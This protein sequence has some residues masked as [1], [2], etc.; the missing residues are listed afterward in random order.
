MNTN[1]KKYLEQLLVDAGQTDL[2]EAVKEQMLEDLNVRLEQRLVLT[3]VNE[4]S[5]EQQKES[6]LLAQ[7]KPTQGEVESFLRANI[8]DY[9]QVFQKVFADFRKLYLGE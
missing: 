5:V 6:E 8:K 1:I 4:L 7:K 9:D 3:A 2:P